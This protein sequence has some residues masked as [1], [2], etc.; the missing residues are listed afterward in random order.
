MREEHGPSFIA[1]KDLLGVK[2]K[3]MQEELP[4]S[5]LPK[6]GATR[7]PEEI[8]RECSSAAYEA[9]LLHGFGSKSV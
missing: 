3:K 2:L 1:A 5:S 6:E 9:W 4:L 8:G 7:R